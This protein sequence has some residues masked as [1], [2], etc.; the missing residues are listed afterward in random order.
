MKHSIYLVWFM[1]ATTPISW[2]QTNPELPLCISVDQ[3][4]VISI[5]PDFNF[6]ALYYSDNLSDPFQ[7][8]LADDTAMQGEVIVFDG[9]EFSGINPFWFYFDSD[10][11]SDTIANLSIQVAAEDNESRARI[12]LR[13]PLTP[14]SSWRD[15]DLSYTLSAEYPAGVWTELNEI[16]LEITTYY[17]TITL[18]SVFKNYRTQLNVGFSGNDACIFHSNI[19]GTEILN[20]KPPATPVTMRVGVDTLSN[21]AFIEWE[22]PPDNDLFGYRV[23]QR[24]A[25]NVNVFLDTIMNI[26]R[27]QY[28]DDGSDPST[29][30]YSYVLEAFD[31]C[32]TSSNPDELVPYNTSPVTADENAQS[33]IWLQSE[34]DACD[35]TV[36]LYWNSYQR[37]P[38]GVSRYEVLIKKNDEEYQ[39]LSELN[40]SDTTFVIQSVDPNTDYCFIV[41]AVRGDLLTFSLSNVH[42]REVNYANLP[43]GLWL[44]EASAFE[45]DQNGIQ[46]K[47]LISTEDDLNF[48]GFNIERS[49]QSNGEFSKIGFIPFTPNKIE[50]VASDSEVSASNG[51]YWYRLQIVDQCGSKRFYSNRINTILLTLSFDE[52]STTNKLLWNSADGRSG[53][54]EGF[55][56]NRLHVESGSLVAYPLNTNNSQNVYEDPL[57]DSFETSGTYC[58]FVTTKETFGGSSI[59]PVSF[60]NTVCHTITTKIWVPN[61]FT[62]NGDDLNDVFKPVLYF[63]SNI[64]Y[65]ME[66][67]DR[68]GR[69][70]FM[71]NDPELGWDGTHKSKELPDG[72]YIYLITYQDGKGNKFVEKGA[73]HLIRP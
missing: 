65:Q 43:T 28:I 46:L 9:L 41:K 26:D 67:V 70:L 24:I 51:I 36:Y 38:Q 69:I 32:I 19:A 72:V 1:F 62:P 45:A 63:A 68:M 48:S 64:N 60:S 33:S 52:S 50:Y 73:I 25:P 10:Q 5:H 71:T 40:P 39:I 3:N 61:A 29:G 14:G 2:S 56:V 15:F 13:D 37:W 47:W 34:F 16:P 58:Y 21:H 7:P 12:V 44:T 18:C 22:K 27:N 4:N 57:S 54:V 20:E 31:S 49:P 17:D 30:I 11:F 59:A 42:C 35:S 55:N 6:S 23:S 8:V 53:L 66:I